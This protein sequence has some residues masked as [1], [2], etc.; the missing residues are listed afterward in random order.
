MAYI[1]GSN[2]I[3]EGDPIGLRVDEGECADAVVSEVSRFR[4][5]V[6]SGTHRVEIRPTLA[7]M[8][9]LGGHE[10]PDGIEAEER[11]RWVG[12]IVNVRSGQPGRRT[13]SWS[14]VNG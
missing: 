6:T 2:A 5:A 11:R 12:V 7:N 1:E 9:F 14:T 10:A 13:S 3:V 4:I 8:L